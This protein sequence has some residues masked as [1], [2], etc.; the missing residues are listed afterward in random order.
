MPIVTIQSVPI[1]TAPISPLL[2]TSV[3]ANAVQVSGT[4]TTAKIF[5]VPNSVIPAGGTSLPAVILPVPG[6]YRLEGEPFKIKAGGPVFVHGTSPTLAVALYYVNY[7]TYNTSAWFKAQT[8]AAS[9][10]L[11]HTT[12]TPQTLVTNAIY[13]WSLEAT[14]QGDSQSNILS[15]NIV[16]TI[17]NNATT[18]T[19]PVTNT[20]TLSTAALPL[21]PGG[22]GSEPSLVLGVGLTFGVSDAANVGQMNYFW[23]E[24]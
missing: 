10:T 2:S 16:Y 14:L 17:G 1:C 21:N 6:T 18:A 9:W 22:M 20:L 24:S 5:P 7:S 12:A 23:L 13:D 11:A 3:N 4:G 8:T 15:G 19:A